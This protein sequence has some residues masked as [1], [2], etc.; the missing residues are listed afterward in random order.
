MIGTTHDF[1]LVRYYARRVKCLRFR[2]LFQRVRSWIRHCLQ[3]LRL[4]LD[5]E[6]YSWERVYSKRNRWLRSDCRR[7]LSQGMRQALLERLDPGWWQDGEFWIDFKRLYPDET[8][9]LIQMGESLLAGRFRLFQQNVVDLP[10]PIR[11]SATLEPGIPRAE[12]P[13]RSYPSIDVHH[14]PLRPDRDVKWCWE[15]NRFQHLLC[16]GACWKLTREERFAREARGRL[17]SWMDQVSYP[18][19]VQW[20]SNLEVGLRALSWARCHILCM[21]SPDW[22]PDFTDRFGTCLYVHARHLEQELTVHH[23]EGNHLLGEASALFCLSVLYPIYAD[24]GRWRKRSLKI[25][26]RI[27]PRLILPDGCYGEQTTGYFKFV[28]EFLF[29]VLHVARMCRL[30]LSRETRERMSAGLDFLKA[31]SPDIADVPQIGDSDTGMGIGWSISDYWDFSPLEASG[32]VLL[33]QPQLADGLEGFPAESFLLLGR[34]GLTAFKSYIGQ[35]PSDDQEHLPER[36]E[37]QPKFAENESART[38]TCGGKTLCQAHREQRNHRSTSSLWRH[39]AQGAHSPKIS[40]RTAKK[41]SNSGVETFHFPHGGYLISRDGLFGVTFDGGPLGIAPGYG[42]G[43]SDGLSFLLYHRRCPVVVDTGTCLYNGPP[44]WRDYFRSHAAHNTLRMDG[45]GPVEPLDTFRWEQP[46]KVAHEPPAAGNGW[47]LLKAHLSWGEGLQRRFVL[48]LFEGAVIVLDS[49][50]GHGEHALEW[51]LHFHPQWELGACT[52]CRMKAAGPT[53]RLE[54]RLLGA[55]PFHPSVL[56]GSN[57][58]MAGWYSRY[59]GDRVPTSTLVW[60]QVIRLPTGALMGFKE[61][62]THV[63]IPSDLPVSELPAAFHALLNSEEFDSFA[64]RS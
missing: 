44:V 5:G 35:S 43:H 26:N 25:L 19:G 29:S 62:G 12:W 55:R 32:A 63:S 52:D 39:S 22:E 51:R 41:L 30:D 14:N 33:D 1:R 10:Q 42:H 4:R 24:A 9:R 13:A 40:C 18:T 16:L 47:V 61:P 31:L 54:I 36:A 17:E 3:D 6:S 27:V 34:Q 59:Y 57:D 8:R 15:L 45:R 20:S 28:L 37:P 2:D 48:H 64:K 7:D 60:S 58:P 49:V 53:G 21:D 11:W 23:A 38:E 50:E 46:L 56:R